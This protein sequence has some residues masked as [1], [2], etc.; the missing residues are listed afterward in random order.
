MI[1]NKLFLIFLILSSF[2]NAQDKPNYPEPKKGYKLVVLELP[3][4]ENEK[5]YKI[6]IT[7][8]MESQI[9]ECAD[10]SFSFPE[11]KTEYLIPPMRWPY[12]IIDA[13]TIEVMEGIPSESNCTSTKRASRK[14]I[15]SKNIF[16]NYA[17]GFKRHFFIPEKW[18]L[19]YRIWK[20]TPN[21]KSVK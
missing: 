10:A 11:I 3:K 19:E 21:Y 8:G 1:N 15:S 20:T 9:N 2:I 4:L 12:Y 6:E 13:G 17:S 18:T 7:F 5:E 14:I 16:E